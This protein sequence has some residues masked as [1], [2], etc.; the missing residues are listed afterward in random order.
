VAIVNETFATKYWPRGEAIGR[1]FVAEG[2]R[3][4]VIGVVADAKYNSLDE[5]AFPVVFY[6]IPPGSTMV[7]HI[8]MRTTQSPAAAAL[9]LRRLIREIDPNVPMPAI[10]TLE[11]TTEVGLLPQRIGAFAT[12][13]MGGLGALMATAGLYGVIAYAV[14][15]R[16]REIG[17]R[18]ALG[19]TRRDILRLIAGG[20]LRL[21]LIGT[22]VGLLTAAL[23]TR[24]LARFLLVGALDLVAFT[25][26]PAGLIVVALIASYV[27]AR[28]A[29][30]THPMHALRA[31]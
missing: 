3:R 5:A 1:S 24:F 29:A 10:A 13:L 12:G 14:G 11:R 2:R 23:V 22:S 19:A 7:R 15:R 28:R 6:P 25:V 31:E 30:R 18:I 21:T 26:V 20:G 8:L 16:T 9:E 17:V 4:T 27:P